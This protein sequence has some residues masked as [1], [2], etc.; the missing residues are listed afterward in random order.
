MMCS[1]AVDLPV[2]CPGEPVTDMVAGVGVDRCRAVPGCEVV[3]VGEAG[4]VA[5]LDEEPGGAGG[6][7]AASSIEVPPRTSEMTTD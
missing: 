4:D 7:D 5:D 6:T 3:A 2:A 1:H